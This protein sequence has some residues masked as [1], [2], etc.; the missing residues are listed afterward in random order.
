LLL[1]E[2]RA[3]ETTQV[4]ARRRQRHPAGGGLPAPRARVFYVSTVTPAPERFTTRG[5]VENSSDGYAAFV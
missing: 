4:W 5:Q 3:S 2:A 1:D